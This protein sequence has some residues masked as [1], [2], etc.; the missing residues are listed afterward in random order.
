MSRDSAISDSVI[1]VV[2]EVLVDLAVGQDWSCRTTPGGAPAN[3]AVGLARLGQ[4][5]SLRA[6]LSGR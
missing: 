6:R 5:V 1:T 3:V 4:R 2:G